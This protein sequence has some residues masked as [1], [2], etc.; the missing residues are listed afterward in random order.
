MSSPVDIED[1]EDE[2]V[3]FVSVSIKSYK[4]SLLFCTQK[5]AGCVG[6]FGHEESTTKVCL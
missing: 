5:S 6:L 1:A 4:A 2:D 3:E